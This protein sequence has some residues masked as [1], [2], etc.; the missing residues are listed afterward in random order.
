MLKEIL[1]VSG[2]PGLYRLISKGGNVSVVE[3]LADKKRLSIF[4]YNK[5][6]S[7][8]DLSIFTNDGE[9][10]IGEVLSKIQEKEYGKTVSI[11]YMKTSM[12]E[13]RAYLAAVLPD[14]DRERIYPTDIR[15]LLKWYDLLIENGITD[16]SEK[17]ENEL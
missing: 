15:K 13:L 5:R 14:Y 1:A 7:L 4:A 9:A 3:S 16:F 2:K 6:I 8:D 10:P 12:D 11:D 17:E